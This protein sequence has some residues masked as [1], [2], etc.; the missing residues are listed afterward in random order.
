MPGSRPE[1]ELELVLDSLAFGG[2]A[3]GRDA[4]GRVVFVAGGAPGDRVVARIV[5][6][7]PKFARAELAR[8][9]AAG[10]ARVA[11]PCP[12]VD[13]CGGCPWQHVAV[14]AQ[15]AAKQAIV[16]RALGKLGARVEPI[17]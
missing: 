4:S 3:V 15:L 8:V 2:E 16:A 7:K 5:E 13:R 1:V 17:A 12:I 10:A 9:V 6:D 14:D 11:P